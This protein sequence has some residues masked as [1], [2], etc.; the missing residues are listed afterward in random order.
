[1]NDSE[2]RNDKG[3]PEYGAMRS[4][5][6]AY[7]PYLY[8]A[9]DRS[10]SDAANP[11]DGGVQQPAAMPA[12]FAGQSGVP[13]GMPGAPSGRPLD[14]ASR[15]YGVNLDDPRQNPLYGRWD[16]YAIMAF[17]FAILFS[18]M[19]VLPAVMGGLAMWRTRTFRMKG[20]GLALAAVII[21]VLTTLVVLW[22]A[23]HGMSVEQLVLD[24]YGLSG[25]VDGSNGGDV[26]QA[27][28]MLAAQAP[29]LR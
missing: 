21:N 20:Y 28:A 24:M 17:V 22:A 27:M 26:K 15:R 10:A 16:A 19:P 12:Q 29:H 6:P 5:F 8:G 4:D 18:S 2:H 13:G 1:M 23:M 25:M 9:P 11:A 3:R 7:D 14:K